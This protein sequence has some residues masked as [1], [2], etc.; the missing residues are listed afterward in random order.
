MN[1]CPNEII[2]YMHEYLDEEI[3]HEHEQVLKEHLHTCEE[4]QKH[5]HELKR[6]IALVQSTS[7][8]QAPNHFTSN[9]M[10]RL[11]KEKKKVG[12]NR[13]LRQHPMLSAASLFLVMMVGTLFSSWNQSE[14]FSFT[15]K[16]ELVVEN[17]TVIVPKGEVIKGDITVKNGDIR[18]E[19]KVQG[20]ITIING[21]QYRASAGKV[22]GDIEEIDAAFEW[23]WYKIKGSFQDVVNWGD[24]QP[25]T[26]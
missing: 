13:W 4:C 20:D 12:V 5:F 8:I 10:A 14:E 16:P 1:T 6:T 24:S 15:K 17:H 9:V 2:D 26:E 3:S 21:N 23:L 11:P 25:A 18:V 7:H 19:G 22:T